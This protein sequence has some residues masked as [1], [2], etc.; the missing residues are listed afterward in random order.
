MAQRSIEDFKA[1]LQGGGVR[2]TMFEVELTF[3]DTVVSDPNLSTN[4]G[5]F[6]IKA[7][8][9]P[10]SN[11]GLIEVPF[12]GRKL[13]VSGDRVFEDWAVTVT[14]DVSFGLRKAFEEWSERIQNHNYALGSNSLNDYFASAI[15]RQ[16]DRDGQQLRAYRFEGIWPQTVDAIDLD[17][18]STDQV[19]EY[20][21]TFAVQYWSAIDSGDPVTSAVA[22]DPSAN[23]NQISS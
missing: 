20:G 4:E 17:F 13:K 18:D 16:L 15:V 5:I 11:V 14:N 12:R 3:P 21:V 6:L 1:V 10:A 23:L 2:P 22:R 8:Q 7:A 9:L 19:E